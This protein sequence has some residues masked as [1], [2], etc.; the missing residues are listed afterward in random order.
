MY[1][2]ISEKRTRQVVDNVQAAVLF[3][4]D[5]GLTPWN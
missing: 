2:T 4:D 3:A 5:D 1:T